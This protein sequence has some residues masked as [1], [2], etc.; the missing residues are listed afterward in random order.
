MASLSCC[1][2]CS[3]GFPILVDSNS[4]LLAAQAGFFDLLSSP[5][6]PCLISQGIQLALPLRSIPNQLSLTILRANLLCSSLHPQPYFC[7]PSFTGLQKWQH[8]QWAG[9]DGFAQ[10]RWKSRDWEEQCC[11]PL[12]LLASELDSAVHSGEGLPSSNKFSG[13]YS[14]R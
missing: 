5:T 9:W 3:S 12:E 10:Q 13:N 14:H 4:F 11:F 1:S 7:C 6:H 8:Y 2:F